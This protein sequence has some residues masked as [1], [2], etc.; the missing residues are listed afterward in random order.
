MRPVWAWTF[1]VTGLLPACSR[2]SDEELAHEAESVRELSILEPVPIRR[3]SQ[4]GYRA[5]EEARLAQI[6]NQALRRYAD[7]YG[8]LGFFPLDLDL[9]PVLVGSGTDFAAADYSPTKKEIR[10]VGDPND[11]VIVH[12][13]VH[14]LQDQHFNLATSGSGMTS[15]ASLARSGIVEGD[16]VL[17]QLRYLGR[18][19]GIDLPDVPTWQI[20]FDH[21]RALADS[22][23][24]EPRYPRFFAA[25]PSFSYSF[26]LEFCVHNLTG[27]TY[28]SPHGTL[29]APYDWTREDALFL[30]DLP[31]TTRDVLELSAADPVATVGLDAVPTALSAAFEDVDWDSLGEWY[32]FLLLV[33][34]EGCTRGCTSGATR[35][36]AAMWNG[37]RALFVADRE[38]GAP[39]VVWGSA[40]LDDSSATQVAALLAELYGFT[41]TDETQPSLGRGSDGEPMWLER[42][43][44]RIVVVKNVAEAAAPIFA[45]AAFAPVSRPKPAPRSRPSLA[46]LVDAR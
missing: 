19:E 4:D 31:A 21:Y 6:S 28:A 36:V 44:T 3:L 13:Y 1:V 15:D 8:R 7:T 5:E 24:S 17:A 22:Q 41:P 37:D 11:D 20:A 45:E 30:G 32:V 18:Q 25:R 26:G 43:T 10:L 33:P 39:G 9:R 35:D 29:P 34:L 42:R 23:V 16:A 40:W 38:T 14:A 12:E 2:A 27:A 46:E